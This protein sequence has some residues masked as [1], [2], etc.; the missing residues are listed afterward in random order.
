MLKLFNCV[1]PGGGETASGARSTSALIGR[2]VALGGL[3]PSRMA[4]LARFMAVVPE[5]DLD[6]GPGWAARQTS[7]CQIPLIA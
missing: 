1:H 2:A 4:I 3:K 7:C 5:P 6:A